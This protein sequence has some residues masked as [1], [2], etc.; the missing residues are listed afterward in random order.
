MRLQI[1]PGKAIYRAMWYV[2]GKRFCRSTGIRHSPQDPADFEKNRQ[3]ALVRGQLMMRATRGTVVKPEMTI[4]EY[5]ENCVPAHTSKRAAIKRLFLD[6]L[7][8]RGKDLMR[9]ASR[10]HQRTYMLMR[11]EELGYTTLA[12]ELRC[13]WDIFAHAVDEGVLDYNPIDLTDIGSWYLRD[14]LTDLQLKALLLATQN[15]EWRTA[16]YLG[17]YTGATLL[18]AILVE[19]AVLKE[20]SEG[21]FYLTLPQAKRTKCR[22]VQVH[23]ALLE[24]L[25]SLRR[26]NNYLCPALSKL[27][28]CTAENRFSEI[29]AA[30]QLPDAMTFGSL[31]RT[32][33]AVI[34][35]SINRVDSLPPDAAMKLPSINIP[36]LPCQ[37]GFTPGTTTNNGNPGLPN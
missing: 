27:E 30:A 9:N 25:N 10:E 23:P 7:G 15:V 24:H 32:H 16:I 33:A 6:A 4:R 20:E 19:W 14:G 1:R 11:G 22:V 18:Q 2:D 8:E 36:L 3:E 29:V 34:G 35:T 17:Y 26:I 37:V 31:K 13:L 28:A 5:L 12:D 21:R